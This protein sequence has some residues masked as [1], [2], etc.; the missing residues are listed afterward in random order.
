MLLLLCV[1]IQSAEIQNE[2][3]QYV[4]VLT[5]FISL[6]TSLRLESAVVKCFKYF[7]RGNES[8]VN[9]VT[10]S[11]YCNEDVKSAVCLVANITRELQE[12]CLSA[13]LANV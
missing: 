13:S 3:V 12:S 9:V 10:T 4:R 1:L 2:Y 8:K 7:S 6:N 5:E 11:F